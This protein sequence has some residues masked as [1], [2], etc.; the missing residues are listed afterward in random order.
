MPGA[1]FHSFYWQTQAA[2]PPPDVPGGK[3]AGGTPSFQAAIF[4]NV[5]GSGF[6]ALQGLW[7]RLFRKVR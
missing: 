4:V 6:G 1:S 2:E 5:V 3:G 7:D